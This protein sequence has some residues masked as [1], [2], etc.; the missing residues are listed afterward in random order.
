M[1]DGMKEMQK[2]ADHVAAIAGHTYTTSPKPPPLV[3][4]RGTGAATKGDKHE[5]S[6]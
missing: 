3:K 5:K 4:T 1:A 2:L 6:D